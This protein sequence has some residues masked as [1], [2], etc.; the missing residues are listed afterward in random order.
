MSLMGPAAAEDLSI[1]ISAF[2]F[3]QN[4]VLQL[5]LKLLQ[6]HSAVRPSYDYIK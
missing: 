1:F 3:V 5:R 4:V 6:K 2:S